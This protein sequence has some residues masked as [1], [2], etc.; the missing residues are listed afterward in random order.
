M[1]LFCDIDNFIIMNH[2]LFSISVPVTE[3]NQAWKWNLCALCK[4]MIGKYT[5]WFGPASVSKLADCHF[6]IQSG[7]GEQKANQHHWV[8]KSANI[9]KLSSSPYCVPEEIE[10]QQEILKIM[11][12]ARIRTFG[13]YCSSRPEELLW[14]ASTI[15]MSRLQSNS[16]LTSY[17]TIILLHH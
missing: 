11:N 13:I 16:L 6:V 17:K 8:K 9:M 12:M 4:H 3:L 2:T 15:F 1:I 14:I 10:I 5:E 7:P